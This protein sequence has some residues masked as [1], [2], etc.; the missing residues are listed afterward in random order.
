MLEPRT[1]GG[2]ILGYAYIRYGL[3]S[4]IMT[5][6]LGDALIFVLLTLFAKL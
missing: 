5:H 6:A 4:A 2:V 1:V 3:E